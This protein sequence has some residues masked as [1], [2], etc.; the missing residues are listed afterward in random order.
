MPL[1][2]LKD[3]FIRFHNLLWGVLLMDFTIWKTRLGFRIKVR[4]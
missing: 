4:G 1:L 3:Q 2:M